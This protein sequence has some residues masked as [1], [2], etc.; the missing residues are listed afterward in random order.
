VP[1]CLLIPH[2]VVQCRGARQITTA[3]ALS[4]EPVGRHH[5]EAPA[6]VEGG[7]DG[8]DIRSAAAHALC[9]LMENGSMYPFVSDLIAT[10]ISFK[11][12]L[13]IGLVAGMAFSLGMLV[14]APLSRRRATRS[15]LGRLLYSQK[16]RVVNYLLMALGFAAWSAG[17]LV[18]TRLG[19][20]QGRLTPSAAIFVMVLLALGANLAVL[21]HILTA[22][23]LARQLITMGRH[24]LP[25]CSASLL[26]LLKGKLVIPSGAG[27]VSR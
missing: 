10:A 1:G 23:R 17:V 7:D 26:P 5:R 15:E 21:I 2:C 20:R 16:Q 11:R 4:D 6:A 13:L 9:F 18:L 22:R 27:L 24:R 25:V 3:G 19:F 8:H 12:D 14:S